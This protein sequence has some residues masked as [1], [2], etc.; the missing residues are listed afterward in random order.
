MDN[1]PSDEG[2]TVEY[3]TDFRVGWLPS[4]PGARQDARQES[5][6]GGLLG[7]QVEMGSEV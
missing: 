7:G 2:P 3:Y 5:A 4:V 6:D 1:M